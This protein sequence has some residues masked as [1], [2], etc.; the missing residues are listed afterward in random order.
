MFSTLLSGT[1]AAG[2]FIPLHLFKRDTEFCVWLHRELSLV[3]H[4]LLSSRWIIDY[5]FSFF[6]L[7]CQ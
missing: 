3:T 5:W 7:H 4:P 6:V 1:S 2:D